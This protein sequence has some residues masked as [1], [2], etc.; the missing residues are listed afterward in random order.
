MKRN[1]ILIIGALSVISLSIASC[2]KEVLDTQPYDKISEDVIWNTKANA[3]TFI[4][5]TYASVIGSYAGGTTP[6]S[7]PFT[8]NILGIDGPYNYAAPVFTGTIDRNTDMGFNNWSQIRRC[9]QIIDKVNASTG[10]SDNDKKALVAEGKFLRAMSYFTVARKIGRIVWIDTVLTPDDDLLLPSTPNP[11]ET[12]KYIIKDLEDA[13]QDLPADKVAGRANKYVAAAMLSEVCLEALA[14]E[15]YPQAP[16]ISPSDPLIQEAI[17]NARLVIEQG[18]YSLE[19]DYGS[20]FN[21]VN[22]ASS[23][24]IMA[25]YRKAINTTCDG[26]FMQLMVPNIN[27]DQITQYGGGPLLKSAIHIFEA[28]GQYYPTQNLADD[29]LVVDKNDPSVAL[30]WNQTSQFKNAVDES[31]AV[32]VSEIPQAG[33]ESS[34]EHGAIKPGSNETVWTLTN[35]GRDARWQSSIISDSSEFYGETL[36]TCIQGNATRWMKINGASYYVSLSNM[37]WRKGIYNN[38]NPRVY[39]GVPTDYHWVITRLGRVYLNLA[40]AYLLKGDVPDAVAAYNMTRTV[41]GKLPPS[42]A[43]TLADAWTDYKR[44]RRVDLTIENDYY[45]SLL[46][47]GRYG[48]P[49]NHNIA[50][51]GIIPELTEVPRA[52]DISKNRKY[53]SIVE[54][55]FFGS[56]NVRVFEKKRY[57]FPIAQSYLDRNTAFG[58]QNANW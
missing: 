19:P 7:D 6:M 12:Y 10:I 23:E 38:V 11:T 37:Y 25:E 20:M 31:A 45:W 9:N 2:T 52:I 44:E 53:F 51:G 39:V 8:A 58:P 50:S 26:T 55:P 16:N 32:P 49:A 15:N 24:I 4:F 14:Y 48:G 42:K 54:G 33:G 3:E 47:W 30:P 56:N 40:E 57:L 28:W 29:Y 22:P 35:E 43:S 13:V 17:D 27:N 5:S 1:I 46:R 21:D 36:T 18:G 34:V 41:H